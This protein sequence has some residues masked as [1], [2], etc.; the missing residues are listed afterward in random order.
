MP[1]RNSGPR[2]HWLAERASYYIFWT[3]RGRSKKRA[4]GTADRK[5]AETSL[6]EFIRA[7]GSEAG[8]RHP[9]QILITDIL[10]NYLNERGPH[11][12]AAERIGHAVTGLVGY[13]AGKTVADITETT[14]LEYRVHRQRSPSTVRRE[15]GVLHAAL[16]HAVDTNVL[17][18]PRKIYLPAESPP[19][20]RWLTRS[21]AAM[22]I[23]G[24]LGFA[25]RSYD[26]ETRKPDRWHRP[27]RPQ[28][29]L[30]LFIL[31]ALYTGRRKEAILSLRWPAV[32]FRNGTIDFRRPGQGDNTK[33]KRGR[34][35]IPDKL[36]PHL[37]RASRFGRELGPV[38]TLNGRPIGDIKKTFGTCAARSP[39]R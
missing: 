34:P 20:E 5:E 21:E 33:K 26:V 17:T 3:E 37:K 10:T 28:Y 24:S 32:D 39:P 15:L 23:A 31:L 18:R 36:L 19:R 2:L 38:I 11:V 4:T 14:C 35:R 25:P 7:R 9:G 8:P 1:R 29:H 13:W 30:A 12:H 16:S 27:A 22:L 6:A